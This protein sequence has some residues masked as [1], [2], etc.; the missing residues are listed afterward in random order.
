M[1]YIIKKII[2]V[3]TYGGHPTYPTPDNKMITRMLHL[4]PDKNKLHLE[5]DAQTAQACKA[6]YK[7]DNRR[8]YDVMI[9]IRKDTDL[10]P[11]VKQHKNKRDGRGAYYVIHSRWLGPNHVNATAS[12]SDMALQMST[13][14]GEK[15]H[16]TVRSTLP[17]M[18]STIL[19]WEIVWNMGTKALIKGHRF[20]TC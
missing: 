4:P 9:Q 7:V 12:E 3:Q 5:K 15:R 16:G 17:A 18:S 20:D 19:S 8:V 10:Y 11:Y 13:Y 1:A 2:T 6:E 14:N